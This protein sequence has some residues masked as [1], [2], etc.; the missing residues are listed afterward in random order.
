VSSYFYRRIR[1]EGQLC[2]AERDLLAIAKFLVMFTVFSDRRK[3]DVAYIKTQYKFGHLCLTYGTFYEYKN[4]KFTG[5]RY[6]M[7]SLQDR[8][9]DGFLRDSSKDVKSRKDVPFGV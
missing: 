1:S 2:D 4:V 5:M 6:Q 3:Y 7:F 9:V 8:P